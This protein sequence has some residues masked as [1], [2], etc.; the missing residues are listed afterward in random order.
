MTFEEIIEFNL[1]NCPGCIDVAKEKAKEIR[2]M[3]AR[4]NATRRT[5]GNL[6][7]VLMGDGEDIPAAIVEKGKEAIEKVK[8]DIPSVIDREPVLSAVLFLLKH[9]LDAL[10]HPMSDDFKKEV[11]PLIANQ[12][13]KIASL[14]DNN[15]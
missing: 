4:E 13:R 15:Q 7:E 11:L 1:A 14:L 5:M 12:L 3:N 9:E 2:E 6:I 8:E 10:G